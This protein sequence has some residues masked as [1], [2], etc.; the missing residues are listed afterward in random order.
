MGIH[1]RELLP[2]KVVQLETLLANPSLYRE[3]LKTFRNREVLPESYIERY[4]QE[5]RRHVLDPDTKILK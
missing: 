1:I 5:V 4:V 2:L 3:R